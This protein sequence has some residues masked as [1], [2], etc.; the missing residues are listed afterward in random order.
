MTTINAPI[1]TDA[2]AWIKE[3]RPDMFVD[4]LA[5]VYPT[6]KFGPDGFT[7]YYDEEEDRTE[8]KTLADHVEALQKLVNLVSEGK[9]WVGGIKNPF[10]LA[11]PC[12]WD[13]EVVDAYFQL[14][15]HGE[16]IYG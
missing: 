14:L 16:V 10:E 8:L 11:D 7:A 9:L 12:N 5:A 4:G 1:F 2:E 13:V 15:F 3:N 6:T